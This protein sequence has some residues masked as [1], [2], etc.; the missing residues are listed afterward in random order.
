MSIHKRRRVIFLQLVVIKTACDVAL[1]QGICP[2]TCRCVMAITQPAAMY[3]QPYLYVVCR[4]QAF[5]NATTMLRE[6]VTQA[7]VAVASPRP[8]TID[9]L[10]NIVLKLL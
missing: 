3:R 2:S 10:H 6:L 5:N 4:L 8:D 1:D 9:I 7:L